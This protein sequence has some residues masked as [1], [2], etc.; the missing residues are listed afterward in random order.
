MSVQIARRFC[1]C[2]GIV[3]FL[4]SKIFLFQYIL[5]NII[6]KNILQ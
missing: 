4:D 3:V 6:L 2:V 5:Q 1:L